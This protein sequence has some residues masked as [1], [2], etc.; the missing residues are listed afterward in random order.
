MFT[1]RPTDPCSH[2]AFPSKPSFQ[3]SVNLN[4]RV[5]AAIATSSHQ[6]SAHPCWL[7]RLRRVVQYVEWKVPLNVKTPGMRVWEAHV[8]APWASTPVSNTMLYISCSGTSYQH[9][10]LHIAHGVL[11]IFKLP[12]QI[13]D[14]VILITSCSIYCI[15]FL[16]CKFSD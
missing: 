9:H 7:G 12:P 5:Q 8:K 14:P 11:R 15:L 1:D 13:K 10:P 6:G 4:T 2:P 16:V 3:S